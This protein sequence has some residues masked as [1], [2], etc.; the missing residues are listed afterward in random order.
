MVAQALTP[1]LR[2]R[3]RQIL[4]VLGFPDLQSEFQASLGYSVKPCLKHQN[5]I[6]TG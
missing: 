2:D 3:G 1:A 6:P 4:Q 5:K